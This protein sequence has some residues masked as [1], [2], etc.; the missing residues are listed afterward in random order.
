MLTLLDEREPPWF[1]DPALSD[2]HGLVAV[3]EKLGPERIKLAYQK[4][5]F[6]WMKMDY[7]PH[8]WC[9]FSPHPRMV[10]NPTELKLSKSTERLLRQNRFEVHIDSQFEATM[11]AC[12]SSERPEQES[13]WIEDDMIHD[14]SQLHQEGVAHSIEAFEEGEMVGGLY[15]L[16][17]GRVFFGESMFHKK[18]NASKVCFAHLAKVAAQWGIELID[19][20]VHS[21]HL[22][23]LGAREIPR[24]EYLNSL[25]QLLCPLPSIVNWKTLAQ[26]YAS[27]LPIPQ[28]SARMGDQ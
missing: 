18:S 7:D 11:R 24:T 20:Q 9:W 17:M 4:G 21:E 25:P 8:F 5:I 28:S 19:C 27:R 22:Q 10:L 23:S 13:T 1:P 3:S 26:D 15:G 2:D 16:A 14:Y 12:A 6:P